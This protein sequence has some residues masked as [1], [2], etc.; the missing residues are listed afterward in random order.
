MPGSPCDTKAWKHTEDKQDKGNPLPDGTVPDGPYQG[1]PLAE[2]ALDIISNIVGPSVQETVA[3]IHAQAP[4]ARIVLMGYPP[5]LSNDALCLSRVPGLGISPDEA[6]WLN[7]VAHYLAQVMFEAAGS[8]RRQ[9]VDVGYVNP[10]A[11]FHGKA[12]CGDPETIHGIVTDLTTSDI[13]NIDWPFFQ[14]GLSNQAFHPKI[15]GARLYADAL[16]YALEGW[17]KS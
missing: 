1:R 7:G 10:Q 14:F 12:I 2:A 8:E 4:N 6:Q 9:G 11:F 3:Q 5:L 17:P 16:E 15:A 13:P